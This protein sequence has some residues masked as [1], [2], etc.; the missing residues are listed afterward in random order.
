VASWYRGKAPDGEIEAAL[1]RAARG[2]PTNPWLPFLLG[3]AVFALGREPEATPLWN[4]LFGDR[5]PHVFYYEY[6]LMALEF[7]R[8]GLPSWADRAF[9]EAL[10]RRRLIPVAVDATHW[11]DRLVNAPFLTGAADARSTERTYVW[12]TRARELTGL[13]MPDEDLVALSWERH[14]RR[15]GETAKAEHERSVFERVERHPL[16][17]KPAR[18]ALEGAFCFLVGGVS[19]FWALLVAAARRAEAASLRGRLAAV[20]ALLAGAWRRASLAAACV[21]VVAS[22]GYVAS[23]S[24]VAARLGTGLPWGDRPATAE[25]PHGWQT[26]LTDWTRLPGQVES[27]LENV[28]SRQA[29]DRI[30][31]LARAWALRVTQGALFATLPLATLLL[32]VSFQPRNISPGIAAPASGADRLTRLVFL[33]APGAFDLFRGSPGFGFVAFASFAAVA[34]AAAFVDLGAPAS[35]L[36]APRL[37][38]SGAWSSMLALPGPAGGPLEHWSLVAVLRSARMLW[39]SLAVAAAAC[40]A[41]HASRV[42]AVWRL[43]RAAPAPGAL[44]L[45]LRRAGAVLLLVQM[46]AVGTAILANKLIAIYEG[47]SVT[48]TW[49]PLIQAMPAL[50]GVTLLLTVVWSPAAAFFLL[51]RL[52]ARPSVREAALVAVLGLEALGLVLLVAWAALS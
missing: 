42:S 27:L 10:R 33:S 13:E 41:L 20:P 12:L 49:A 1:R 4:A 26:R 17:P 16:N 51:R 47:S 34:S 15:A 24:E 25:L 9:E 30:S 43:P 50:L 31:V 32:I 48:P 52:R 22:A 28:P 39:A 5:L 46:G 35:G 14:F 36:L 6:S 7:E 3:Q 44:P 8:L 19:G 2:D 40:L 37:Y 11:R 21:V 29:A 23:A 38:S 18:A 45:W